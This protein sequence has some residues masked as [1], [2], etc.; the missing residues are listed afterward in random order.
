M[1][2]L[3]TIIIESTAMNS[4]WEFPISQTLTPDNSILDVKVHL[5]GGDSFN[6]SIDKYDSRLKVP[7]FSWSIFNNKEGNDPYH[8]HIKQ[9]S[10]QKD[11]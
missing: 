3:D 9:F 10:S 11:L 1:W 5:H 2:T 4:K 8:K 6:H 7:H